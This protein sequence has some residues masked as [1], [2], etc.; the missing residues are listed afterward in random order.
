MVVEGLYKRPAQHLGCRETSARA[1]SSCVVKRGSRDIRRITPVERPR[2][3]ENRLR[4]AYGHCD[5]IMRP[6]IRFRLRV[7]RL[8]FGVGQSEVFWAL[9]LRLPLPASGGWGLEWELDREMD[10]VDQVIP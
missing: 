6:F 1:Y 4:I 10:L 7:R 3:F 8:A 5:A 2:S 9:F